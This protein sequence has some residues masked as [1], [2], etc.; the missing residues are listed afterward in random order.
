MSSLEDDAHMQ[1]VSEYQKNAAECRSLAKKAT[2]PVQ[3]QQF[4]TM[5]E[6][7]EALALERR[8]RTAVDEEMLN[9][10]PALDRVGLNRK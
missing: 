10:E 4:T 2:S 6:Q 7:W 9:L 3:R 5:A 1:R 8:R